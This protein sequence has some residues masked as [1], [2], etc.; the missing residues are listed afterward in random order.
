MNVHLQ[1][2]L[3][4]M[5]GLRPAAE[6]WMASNIMPSTTIRSHPRH[7]FAPPSYGSHSRLHLSSPNL[8]KQKLAEDEEDDG[9]WWEVDDLEVL[10][11]EGPDFDDDEDED[12]EWIPDGE[13]ARRNPRRKSAHL[14]PA[15]DVIQ[16]VLKYKKQ[17]SS[18]SSSSSSKSKK[19]GDDFTSRKPSP[20]TEEEEEL[21][22]L[23]GGK[24]QIATK[25]EE[26]FLGDCTLSE[27]AHDYSVPICYLAD[28]LCMWGV[29]APV[30]THDRLG[31]LVTGEQCFAIVEAIYSLDI[32][33]LNDRYSNMSIVQVCDHWEIELKDAFEFAM[34]EGWSLP[35]GVQ[36]NLRVEQ[37][38]ELLRNFGA[39]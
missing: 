26:G 33:A 35:F 13:L 18:S 1:I 15:A 14:T 30:N 25:R 20:Y 27:I 4:M 7:P 6:A 2:S 28:V 21:I 22:D 32:G 31:D 24:E 12:F 19:G 11:G 29:P 37:E 34:K 3:M 9:D 10:Q 36:T 38:D 39:I 5:L 16:N 23:L 8:S 17:S